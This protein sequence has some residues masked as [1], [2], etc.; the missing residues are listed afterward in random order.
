[1]NKKL[2]SAYLAIIF[3]M[4][5]WACSFLFTQELSLIELPSLQFIHFGSY[6]FKNVRQLSIHL[7]SLQSLLLETGSLPSVNTSSIECISFLFFFFNY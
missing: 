7:P 6:A 2:L 1:M 3:A 4:S 5:V